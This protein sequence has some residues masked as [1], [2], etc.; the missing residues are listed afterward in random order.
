M[1]DTTDVIKSFDISNRINEGVTSFNITFA[2]PLNPNEYV[3]GSTFEFVLSDITLDDEYLALIG[4]VET[5]ERQ[6]KDHNRIYAISGR[7]K[8][9]LLTKQPFSLDCD[10]ENPRTYTVETLLNKILD[11]TGI[12]IGRG[13][14]ELDKK[15]LL[16]TNGE[17]VKRFCGSWNSKQEAINQ[18]FSQY[19][20]FS[21]ANKFRWF[22]DYSGS[23]RWFETSFHERLSN[24]YLF[25]DDERITNFTVKEDATGVQ[26]YFVGFYGAEEDNTSVIVQDSTSISKF[27]KCYAEPITETDMSQDEITDKLNK[28]LAQKK[29][30]IYTASVEITGFY[31]IEPGTQIQFPNDP[32][33]DEIKFTVTDWKVE[34]TPSQPKTRINLTSDESAISI[35]NEFDVISATANKAAKDNR[36][37]T[38]V[39]QKTGEDSGSDRCMVLINGGGSGQGSIV[40]VRNPGAK[41]ITR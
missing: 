26:N 2:T 32:Y 17:E 9:R 20:R 40:S 3:S 35:A 29:N 28:E 15:I 37:T 27:G 24:M 13:Q 18:L 4:I 23:F 8:G 6:S 34:G 36:A 31:N 10:T 22:I 39:V 38:G 14:T 12:T 16:S 11:G 33:Y 5:V 41:W 7:D 1:S 25:E 19:M 21:G 30:A